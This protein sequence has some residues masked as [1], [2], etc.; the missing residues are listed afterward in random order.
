MY[1]TPPTETAG[2]NVYTTSVHFC[3]TTELQQLHPDKTQ[4]AFTHD[5]IHPVL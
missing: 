5:D 2:L 4:P 1:S 3:L